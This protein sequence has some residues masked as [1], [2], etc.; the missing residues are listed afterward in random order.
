LRVALVIDGEKHA[1]RGCG[2][3]TRQSEIQ[4]SRRTLDWALSQPSGC[5]ISFY[6]VRRQ[7]YA[8]RAGSNV[9]EVSIHR[10]Q[11]RR[12][13]V[14][15]PLHDGHRPLNPALSRCHA[16][17]AAPNAWGRRSHP[18]RALAYAE[19]PVLHLDH[20]SIHRETG[21]AHASLFGPY[22]EAPATN[23]PLHRRHSCHTSL[24]VARG[25]ANG[26]SPAPNPRYDDS[27]IATEERRS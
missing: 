5:A 20:A 4:G 26:L 16:G 13:S 27:H 7:L 1:S 22:G 23:Q 15:P 14:T 25:G 24:H 3:G 19:G 6:F 17:R 18:P 2:F 12:Y 9:L 11:R 10:R 8:L 21:P